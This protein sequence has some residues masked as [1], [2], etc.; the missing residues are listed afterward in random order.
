MEYRLDKNYFK[1][2]TVREADHHETY[3][4][5]KSVEERLSA[6]WYLTCQ[7]FNIS[8]YDPPGIDNTCFNKR[9]REK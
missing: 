1:K 3:W 6:A 5:G 4:Q 9:R 2:Q 7:A 8:F